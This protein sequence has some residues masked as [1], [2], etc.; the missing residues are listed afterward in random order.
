MRTVT[1]PATATHPCPRRFVKS[2]FQPIATAARETALTWLRQTVTD[3]GFT[4]VRAYRINGC[5]V[6]E[7]KR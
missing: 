5:P 4:V 7:L 1:V 2:D 6:V 3:A